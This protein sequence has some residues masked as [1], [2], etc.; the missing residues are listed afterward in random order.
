MQGNFDDVAYV[1]RK[2]HYGHVSVQV[3]APSKG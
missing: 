2:E 1:L 3:A